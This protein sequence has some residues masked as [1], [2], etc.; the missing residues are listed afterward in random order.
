MQ[1]WQKVRLLQSK[2]T[3]KSY[4]VK[5]IQLC[6]KEKNMKCLSSKPAM[7]VWEDFIRKASYDESQPEYFHIRTIDTTGLQLYYLNMD[8]G[9]GVTMTW[10]SL[11]KRLEV[12][13]S[14]VT[15]ETV[16]VQVLVGSEF[17]K[18]QYREMDVMS[19]ASD[20]VLYQIKTEKDCIEVY[21]WTI[22]RKNLD[23]HMPFEAEP[24]EEPAKKIDKLIEKENSHVNISQEHSISKCKGPAV[25]VN[26]IHSGHQTRICRSAYGTY[27]ALVTNQGGGMNELS[28]VKKEGEASFQTIYKTQFPMDTSSANVLCDGDGH[29]W[30]FVIPVDKTFHGDHERA[31]LAAYHIEPKTDVVTE[32]KR[33]IDFAFPSP[34]GYGYSQPMYEPVHNKVL[35]IFSGGDKPGHLSWFTFDITTRTWDDQNLWIETDY[36]YCYHYLYP[37]GKG[38]FYLVTERDIQKESAGFPEITHANYSWDALELFEVFDILHPEHAHVSV[39]PVPEEKIGQ[40]LYPVV[41]NNSEGDVFLDKNG[42]LHVIYAIRYYR[43]PSGKTMEKELWHKAFRGLECVY[44]GKMEYQGECSGRMHQG[45][46]GRHYIY[47]VRSGG[48]RSGVEIWRA[49]DAEG[50]RYELYAAKAFAEEGKR[51][52]IITGDVRNGSIQDGITDC[53]SLEDAQ[54]GGKFDFCCFQI[55]LQE[56]GV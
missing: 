23:Y 45:K 54:N 33:V 7:E 40:N 19:Q 48:P 12:Y 43:L 39:Q 8:F 50:F 44:E 4:E 41:A 51:S 31:W 47:A 35:A 56:E 24:D 20:D 29:V 55:E 21:I 25:T 28:I 17:L 22:L 38:G 27:L 34:H 49:L 1:S 42:I 18:R 13:V 5:Y 46:D 26:G 6:R 52:G 14:N 11:A 32:Y 3:I 36:R 10:R 53:I 30:V 37:N 15:G 2:K 9:A 16:S